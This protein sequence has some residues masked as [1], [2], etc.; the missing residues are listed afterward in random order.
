[1]G[2]GFPNISSWDLLVN[3]GHKSIKVFEIIVLSWDRDLTSIL[4][5]CRGLVLSC[6]SN[7]FC[8]CSLRDHHIR[9]DEV[10][11]WLKLLNRTRKAH[12]ICRQCKGGSHFHATLVSR[13]SNESAQCTP[14]RQCSKADNLAPNPNYVLF[15]VFSSKRNPFH[16]KA[17]TMAN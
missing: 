8:Q 12:I 4:G 16:L 15:Q 7:V 5:S 17:T 10:Q 6:S 2:W 13:G 11:R 1:M 14:L 9:R 3:F